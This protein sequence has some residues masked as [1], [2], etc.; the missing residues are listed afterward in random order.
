MHMS[1]INSKV[2]GQCAFSRDMVAEFA[3]FV[4]ANGLKPVI[5]QE[6]GFDQT[7]AAFEAL[8]KQKFVGKV[9]VRIG[10]DA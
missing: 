2:R 7:I 10:E 5:G 3:Q 4:E 8:E 6:F 9:V 1:L